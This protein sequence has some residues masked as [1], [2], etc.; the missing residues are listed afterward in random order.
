MPQW[1]ASTS[2]GSPDTLVFCAAIIND[3][4]PHAFLGSSSGAHLFTFV[5]LAAPG[6]NF[7]SFCP[8]YIGKPP[9]WR[10]ELQISVKQFSQITDQMT[11]VVEGQ[12]DHPVLLLNLHAVASP[13]VTNVSSDDLH[14]AGQ[15]LVFTSIRV[16][17]TTYPVDCTAGS[18]CSVKFSNPPDCAKKKDCANSLGTKTDYISFVDENGFTVPMMQLNGTTL[19]PV[20][21]TYTPPASGGSG[22]GEG[23]S[24]KTGQ[25]TMSLNVSGSGGGTGTST[26]QTTPAATAN[27]SPNVA[28]PT[29]SATANAPAAPQ[30][31]ATGT[32]QPLPAVA[33]QKKMV[34]VE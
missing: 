26:T 13:F 20:Q 31:P 21:Y 8:P 22:G 2:N 9:D 25:F 7:H 11:F 18:I 29:T 17:G 14:F 19:S 5:D 4:N 15:N 32:S 27:G 24:G 1:Y 34:I 23:A 16:A 12:Q 28:A 6:P 3:S 10:G 33:P 30:A